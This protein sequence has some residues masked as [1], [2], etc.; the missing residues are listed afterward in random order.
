MLSVMTLTGIL[1]TAWTASVWKIT[2]FSWQ[3][4]PI[5]LIG[6]TTP[7]SLLAYMIETRMVWS[8]MARL[9]VFDIDQ[10]IGL[11]GQ[12]GHAEA[13]L[14]KLL[15]GVEHGLVLGHL[16]D[17]VV[18]ALAVHL[19][20]ALEGEI[21]RLGRAGGE[22]DLLGGATDELRDLFARLVHGLL[23]FPAE[24][25]V[26]AGGV[27]EDAG[28]VGHHGFEHTRIERCGRMVV[29]VDREASLPRGAAR[30]SE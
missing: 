13:L 25:V 24:A 7:I 20:D 17:D 1:P 28:E 3:S 16:S 27:A 12:V 4:A 22:D 14:F 26:A 2:P 5:S 11:H 6:W 23:G 29:H 10:A 21:V 15:A 18:A 30:Q 9:Q 8:S 19:R